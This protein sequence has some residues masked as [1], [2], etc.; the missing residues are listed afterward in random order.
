MNN[1]VVNIYLTFSPL[2]VTGDGDVTY[3][4]RRNLLGA[5]CVGEKT[6]YHLYNFDTS[7]SDGIVKLFRKSGW[8]SQYSTKKSN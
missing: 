2:L 5:M 1:K 8:H 7:K 4:P 3:N 6:A